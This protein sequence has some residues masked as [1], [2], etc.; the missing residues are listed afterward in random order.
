MLPP[1]TYSLWTNFAWHIAFLL[2]LSWGYLWIKLG[3]QY[4]K[5]PDYILDMQ[6]SH[7]CY[8]LLI[9]TRQNSQ[10][11]L[12][13]LLLVPCACWYYEVGRGEKEVLG[14]LIQKL[15]HKGILT[16]NI[17]VIQM[18]TVD[19]YMCLLKCHLIRQTFSLHNRRNY[20]NTKLQYSL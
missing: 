18:Q 9:Q 3:L 13:L 15:L 6:I 7:I 8:D 20:G 11:Y 5:F 19:I 2:Q 4:S 1:E 16:D 10:H 14:W 17:I 12:Q